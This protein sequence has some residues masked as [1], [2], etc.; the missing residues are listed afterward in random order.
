[1]INQPVI[2]VLHFSSEF[3]KCQFS[4]V[5][6]YFYVILLQTVYDAAMNCGGRNLKNLLPLGLFG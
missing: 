3:L 4:I 6:Y 2:L 5:Y 1:M